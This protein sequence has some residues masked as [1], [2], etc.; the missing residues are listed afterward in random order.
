[1][2][3]S[4]IV[5]EFMKLVRLIGIFPITLVFSA[6]FLVAQE[7]GPPPS[8]CAPEAAIP[9]LLKSALCTIS[10]V[11][12]RP[13]HP[14]IRGIA[15]GGGLGAGFEYDGVFGGQWHASAGAA[16]TLRQSWSA[17]VAAGYRG[18]RARVEAYARMRD[19]PELGFFGLGIE[20]DLADHSNYR[21][22]DGVVGA[23]ASVRPAPWLTIGG[24]VEGIWPEVRAGRSSRFPSIEAGFDESDAP[25]LTTQPQFVRSQA[26]IDIVIPPGLGEAFYQG[27]KYRITYAIHS[28]RELDRF[29]F[30]RLDVEA[31]QRF[32]LLGPLRRLTLH[33]WVSITDTDPGQEV[34]FYFQYTLG[35][36]WNLRGVQEDL[37]GSDGTQATL[38]GFRHFRFRDR[39]L[40]LLQAEYRIP[41]WGPVDVSLFAEAGKVTSRRADLDLTDLKHDFGFSLSLMRGPATAVR[42][43]VGFG[44]GEAVQVF[45]SLR[46]EVV[47]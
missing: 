36:T 15:P 8:R 7:T 24:R 31:Q 30:H 19:L 13:L 23:L 43:D 37:I 39:N 34:P 21:L 40:L 17:E 9:P 32:A 45:F 11:Y 35:G 38:R 16:V 22:R 25:G 3:R 10:S 29:S 27:A 42:V 41:V 4:R 12:H 33:G 46:R 28:D 20:S 18:T 1:M 26:S 2:R 44:G 47:P 5:L 6:G 14:I